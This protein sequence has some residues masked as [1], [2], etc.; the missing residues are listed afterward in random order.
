M[1][2][3]HHWFFFHVQTNVHIVQKI[4]L[5]KFSL[6]A[7]VIK[8]PPP[9]HPQSIESIQCQWSGNTKPRTSFQWKHHQGSTTQ[10]LYGYLSINSK[11]RQ[12]E[13][14]V[15]SEILQ[16]PEQ[17]AWIN[18]RHANNIDAICASSIVYNA[19][20]KHLLFLCVSMYSFMHLLV[21][22]LF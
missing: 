5:L 13:S 16:I 10:Y 11:H 19:C 7:N 18:V 1:R 12:I 15:V 21:A 2:K 20:C 14:I 4:Y 22:S 3:F 9:S 8:S 6:L 17:R